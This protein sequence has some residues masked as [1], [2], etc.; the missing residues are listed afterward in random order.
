MRRGRVTRHGERDDERHVDGEQDE[1]RRHHGQRVTR[2]W[3][4][5]NAKPIIPADGS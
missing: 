3:S 4:W 1:Q 5:M 2:T